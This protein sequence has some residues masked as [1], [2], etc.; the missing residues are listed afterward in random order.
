MRTYDMQ[1]VTFKTKGRFLTLEVPGLAERR[2]SLVNG[3]II[4]A[5]AASHDE[6]KVSPLY[7]VCF[8]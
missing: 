7:K 3:D 1:N 5:K 2:P 8:T 4:I 6:H